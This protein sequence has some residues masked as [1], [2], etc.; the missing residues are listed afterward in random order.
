MLASHLE[1]LVLNGTAQ[2]FTKSVGVSPMVFFEIPKGKAAV[3]LNVKS[4]PFYNIQGVEVDGIGGILKVLDQFLL[5][6]PSNLSA[7]DTYILNRLTYQ[8]TFYNNEAKQTI[9]NKANV[10]TALNVDTVSS[11]YNYSLNMVPKDLDID[12]YWAFKNSFWIQTNCNPTYN[13][14]YEVATLSEFGVQSVIPND[15]PYGYSGVQVIFSDYQKN[16]TGAT[17]IYYP[18]QTTLNDLSTLYSNGVNEIILP[19]WDDVNPPNA[20]GQLI[21]PGKDNYFYEML[22]VIT[23]TYALINVAVPTNGIVPDNLLD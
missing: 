4:Q 6:N 20:N 23:L 15:S 9:I 7:F 16:D 22:P 18:Q 1:K 3:I 11:V 14:Q 8:H 5:T 2:I 19:V 13:N 17:G 10:Q 12:T 21:V